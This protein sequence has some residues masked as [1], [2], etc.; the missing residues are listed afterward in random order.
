MKTFRLRP[1]TA[2]RHARSAAMSNDPPDSA[3]RAGPDSSYALCR[4]LRDTVMEKIHLIP[5]RCDLCTKA[6]MHSDS[7]QTFESVILL[8]SGVESYSP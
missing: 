6:I 1:G 7:A 2:T 5:P 4:N 3:F 8:A